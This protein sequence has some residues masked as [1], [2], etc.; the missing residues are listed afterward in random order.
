MSGPLG[1]GSGGGSPKDAQYV[2]L[3]ANAT[4]TQERVLAGTANRITITDGGAG[5]AVTLNTGSYVV[6]NNQANTWTTGTQTIETGA[7]GTVGLVVKA[8]AG[9]TAA[10]QQWQ[11]ST[12]NVDL[13]VLANGD[14]FTDRWLAQNSNTFIGVDVV[15]AGTLAHTVGNEGYQNTFVGNLTGQNVTS[16]YRNILIGYRAGRQITTGA[17]NVIIGV[18]AGN[19]TTGIQNI[20]FGYFCYGSAATTGVGNFA[21]GHSSL[22]GLTSG[23]GNVAI[24][25]NA[26]QDCT[27]GGGNVG[28]G[29]QAVWNVQ[30]ANAN[31]GVGDNTLYQNISGAG[32]VAIGGNALFE[33]LGSRSVGIGYEAGRYS[34]GATSVY[35]G[36]QAGPPSGGGVVTLNSVLFIHNAASLTPLIYGKFDGG[37]GYGIRI[38]SPATTAVTLTARMIA[39]QTANLQNWEDSAGTALLEVEASGVHDYRWAMGDSTK[40]PTTDAP[41]D[42]VEVK[43]GGTTYYLPA[44]AA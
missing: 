16:G 22:K 42:W 5:A 6:L 9:Q 33:A 24:G 31:V 18:D 11:S 20:G 43:I 28:I 4:L 40:D 44:Y 35:I 19:I 36:N 7:A 25:S 10:R 13:A 15:G 14:L 23:S 1:T 34:N 37:G 27:T 26:L 38:H 39:A 30:T 29:R 12:G 32:N 3:V 2:V 17:E 21:L 8:A 41:A